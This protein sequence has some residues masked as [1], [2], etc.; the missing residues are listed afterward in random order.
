VDV[1]IDEAGQDQMPAVVNLCAL[2]FEVGILANSINETA[3]DQNS[4]I[5]NICERLKVVSSPGRGV[6]AEHTAS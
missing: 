3:I 5:V 4:S 6:K 2:P 1:G